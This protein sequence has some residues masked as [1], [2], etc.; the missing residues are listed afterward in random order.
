MEIKNPLEGP[1]NRMDMKE[2]RFNEPAGRSIE[3]IQSKQ[4][5]NEKNHRELR[6]NIKKFSTHV[7]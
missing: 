4:E 5:K 7:I 2:E 6:D 3:I 1:N